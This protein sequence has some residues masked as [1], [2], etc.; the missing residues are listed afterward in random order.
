MRYSI[1]GVNCFSHGGNLFGYTAV[2]RY[3]PRDSISIAIMMN[4]DLDER[5]CW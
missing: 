2:M 5:T 3:D 4:K 1:N